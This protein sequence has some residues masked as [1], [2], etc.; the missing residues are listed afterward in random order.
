MAR[1]AKPRTRSSS[2]RKGRR[3]GC[4]PTVIAAIA[5]RVGKGMGKE[6]AARQA[7]VPAATFHEWM[8]RGRNGEKPYAELAERIEGA[9]STLQEKVSDVLTNGLESDNIHVATKV[10]TWMAERLWPDVYGRR[11]EV[12]TTGPDGGAVKVE[13]EVEGTLK[14]QP[15]LSADAAASLDPEQL[16]ALAR[17]FLATKG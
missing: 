13:V 8:A 12:R 6:A 15:F 11:S 5:L 2:K 4:T 10:G 14:V 7:G 17:E 3:T 9:S 1:T 16:A